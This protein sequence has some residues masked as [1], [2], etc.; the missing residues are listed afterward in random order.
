MAEI[1]KHV[2]AEEVVIRER[3]ADVQSKVSEQRTTRDEVA[4]K[5]TPNVLARY[6]TI[7]KAERAY[8]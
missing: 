1:R 3:M 5:V 6:R 7:R 8:I 2:D 4:A